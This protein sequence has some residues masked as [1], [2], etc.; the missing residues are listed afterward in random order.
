MAIKLSGYMKI[1][2]W[3]YAIALSLAVYFWYA[4]LQTMKLVPTP[5]MEKVV[6]FTGSVQATQKIDLPSLHA[7]TFKQSLPTTVT[8]KKAKKILVLRFSHNEQGLVSAWTREDDPEA[9]R[10]SS[11]NFLLGGTLYKQSKEFI[12]SD[13]YPRNQDYSIG[14]PRHRKTLFE[15]RIY[16]GRHFGHAYRLF[17]SGYTKPGIP[18]KPA[19]RSGTNPR[20][21]VLFT[22]WNSVAR[23]KKWGVK[24]FFTDTSVGNGYPI[25][26]WR[27]LWIN[28]EDILIFDIPYGDQIKKG[29]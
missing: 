7:S 28:P 3:L 10:Y 18:A 26:A 24:K 27:L 12:K 6:T 20:F 11:V 1:A 4:N 9:P 23:A 29:Y 25:E 2:A 16:D 5:V 22:G 21:D 17:V 19:T 13:T 15:A 8:K 14:I